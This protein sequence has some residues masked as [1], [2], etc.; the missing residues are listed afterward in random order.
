MHCIGGGG[1]AAFHFLLLST[2]TI[3]LNFSHATAQLTSSICF[4]SLYTL[5]AVDVECC[6]RCV[7][8]VVCVNLGPK[9]AISRGEQN[10]YGWPRRTLLTARLIKSYGGLRLRIGALVRLAMM[11]R[12][13]FVLNLLLS[14]I[15]IDNYRWCTG[16]ELRK[17]F[18]RKSVT[19]HTVPSTTT[20]Q[21]QRLVVTHT[22]SWIY[23]LQHCSSLSV[24][25]NTL[26]ATEYEITYGVCLCVCMCA[27]TSFWAEYLAPVDN[28]MKWHVANR[29]VTWSITSLDPDI[30]GYKYLEIR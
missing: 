2:K 17:N 15:I 6:F 14:S 16:V 8:L 19:T 3:S 24:Q 5:V 28:S 13:V 27:R 30:F 22:H 10:R 25:C 23:N 11:W 9:A 7:C 20:C 18:S 12:R 29:M 26:H 1:V 4:S 21:V